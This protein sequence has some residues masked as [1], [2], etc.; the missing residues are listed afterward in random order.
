MYRARRVRDRFT[1]PVLV[2]YLAELGI[3]VDDHATYG[4]AT[5]IRQIVAW[6]SRQETLQQAR[7]MWRID[8]FGGVP[9]VEQSPARRAVAGRGR[10]ERP[11]LRRNFRTGQ[12]T[13]GRP[14]PSLVV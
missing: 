4:Q 12:G 14:V 2:G 11:R 8:R 10:S 6:P 3:S 13:R 9:A 5:L 1:R 7:I